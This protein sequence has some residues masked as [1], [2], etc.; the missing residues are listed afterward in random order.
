MA[1]TKKIR[2]TMRDMGIIATYQCGKEEY[3]DGMCKGHY[4]RH[5]QKL[6][7]WGE[8]K[9]YIPASLDHFDTGRSMK[10][11]TDHVNN[12]YRFF[13][14]TI[15]KSGKQGIGWIDTTIPCDVALFVV[16]TI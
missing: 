11:A 2:E 4:N 10:L 14:G 16:K 5:L 6:T 9:D 7:P 12:I 13:R 3:K 15:Q 1:C 8:R